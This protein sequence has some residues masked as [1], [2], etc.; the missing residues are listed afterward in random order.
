MGQPDQLINQTPTALVPQIAGEFNAAATG[1]AELDGRRVGVPCR[2]APGGEPP[3]AD[4]A[5]VEGF[6]IDGRVMASRSSS[7]A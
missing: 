3:H 4:D 1:E 5:G 2:A 7:A 6:E